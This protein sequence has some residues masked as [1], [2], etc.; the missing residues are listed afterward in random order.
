MNTRKLKFYALTLLLGGCV[1]TASLHPLYTDNN[2]IL[3]DRLEGVWTEHPDKPGID[4]KFERFVSHKDEYEKTYKLTLHE[5]GKIKG[6]FAARL[7]KLDDKVYL[8]LSP[9][10]FPFGEKEVE[11]CDLPYNSPFF[12]RVHSFMALEIADSDLAVKMMM[13][14]QIKELFAE[15]PR[16][17]WHTEVDDRVVLTAPTNRLQ[18]F[19]R[20]NL[21]DERLFAGH[22]TLQRIDAVRDSEKEE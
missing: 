4:W 6:L 2:L 18:Q 1:P 7:L 14:K 12:L 10:A 13:D 9:E 3:D 15:K 20:E 5:D 16:A 17:V 11:Q 21:K 8:D 19:I 22:S